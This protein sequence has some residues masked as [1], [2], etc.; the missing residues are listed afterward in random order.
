MS[1]FTALR[2]NCTALFDT[3]MPPLL[4]GSIPSAPSVGVFSTSQLDRCSMYA[5]LRADSAVGMSVAPSATLVSSRSMEATLLRRE[6]ELRSEY[7]RLYAEDQWHIRQQRE[8]QRRQDDKAERQRM[9]EAARA[10]EEERARRVAE[11][12]EHLLQKERE[13]E[14]WKLE[15]LK[16]ANSA[17]RQQ[18]QEDERRRELQHERELARVKEEAASGR[19]AEEV[20]VAVEQSLQRMQSTMQEQLREEVRALEA[21]HRSELTR[22]EEEWAARVK[23]ME[24]SRSTELAELTH[25][26]QLDQTRATRSEEQLREARDQLT[27]LLQEVDQLRVQLQSG[28]PRFERDREAAQRLAETHRS[29]IERLQLMYDDDKRALQRRYMEDRERAKYEQDRR[30]EELKESHAAVLRGKDSEIDQ[31]SDRVRQLERELQDESTKLALLRTSGEQTIPMSVE[32]ARLKDEVR[33]LLT[34]KAELEETT[35]RLERNL[36]EADG[37]VENQNKQLRTLQA[38]TVSGQR[39]LTEARD[40]LRRDNADLKSQIAMVRN[41]YEEEVMRL[42]KQLKSTEEVAT[43]HDMQDMRQSAREAVER[44]EEARRSTE[45][46]LA[47]VMRK[48]KFAEE[49]VQSS[50]RNAEAAQYDVAQAQSR[51]QELQAKV[52]E[53]AAQVRAL[54]TELQGKVNLGYE[55]REAKE[56]A[57]R[58]QAEYDAERESRRRQHEAA[59]EAKDRELQQC[60]ADMLTVKQ[61]FHA[62]RAES[63][64]SKLDREGHQQR[65]TRQLTERE[66]EVAQLRRQLEDSRQSLQQWKATYEE[67]QRSRGTSTDDYEK[68]VRERDEELQECHRRLRQMQG[69]KA[70]LEDRMRAEE[71]ARISV[72]AQSND[73]QRSLREREAQIEQ[74]EREVRELRAQPALLSALAVPVAS[75]L[76]PSGSLPPSLPH[77]PKAP[78]LSSMTLAS[79]PPITADI[80]PTSCAAPPSVMLP[81]S[82]PKAPLVPPLHSTGGPTAA[83]PAPVSAWDSLPPPPRPSSIP[84][85]E[86]PHVMA[87]PLTHSLDHGTASTDGTTE[88]TP[89]SIPVPVSLSLSPF[90]VGRQSGDGPSLTIAVP[91]PAGALSHTASAAEYAISPAPITVAPRSPHSGAT[92]VQAVHVPST[93]APPPLLGAQVTPTG[94]TSS[95]TLPSSTAPPPVLSVAGGVLSGVAGGP[96]PVPVPVLSPHATI[97]VPKVG[98]PSVPVPGPSCASPSPSAGGYGASPPPPPIP[99]LAAVPSFTS[100]SVLA[101][102][103]NVDKSSRHDHRSHRHHHRA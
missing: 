88:G 66:E 54:E 56:R 89:L 96:T 60:R 71:A 69:E 58:L 12:Q 73:V 10:I 4:R 3:A 94:S 45:N 72:T 102:S 26:L 31:L 98:V 64:N 2:A 40:E 101:A 70:G 7:Y 83:P 33:Q 67:L 74:L 55:V 14:E 84:T 103:G 38:D 29:A 19:K 82:T 52:E 51:I 46:S 92:A 87:V 5:G 59:L 53:R 57:E 16:E 22:R 6:W 62:L 100:T 65:L 36:R 91:T 39:Q 97:P 18:Q 95:F 34:A 9:I 35:K 61:R 15:R 93:P 86:K 81:A 44:A 63:D 50:R 43:Q 41:S 28:G 27:K 23:A 48:L 42:Q 30:A 8:E 99:V 90:Q 78:L 11:Q 32:N 24:I 79:A 49:E 20:K 77:A 37:R 13:L 47:E 85:A 75:P 25:Q 76:P 80:T 17:R 1:D 21:A 68:V